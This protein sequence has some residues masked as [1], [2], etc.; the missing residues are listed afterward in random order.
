MTRILRILAG[1]LIAGLLT[2]AV[3]AADELPDDEAI[4][5]GH[6]YRQTG[7]ETGNGY[8]V[9]DNDGITNDLDL[10][11]D[12]DGCPDAIEGGGIFTITDLNNNQL[13]GHFSNQRLLGH[14]IENHA[15]TSYDYI[16][17]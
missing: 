14:P 7:Q 12:G 2:V 16:P 10:D 8:A 17:V 11:S 5:G 4:P 3:T 13:N 9:T 15:I 1:I 6:F